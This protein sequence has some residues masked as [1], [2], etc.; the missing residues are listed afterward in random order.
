MTDEPPIYDYGPGLFSE[1][2]REYLYDSPRGVDEFSRGDVD[3][4]EGTDVSYSVSKIES[5]SSRE[6][7]VRSRIRERLVNGIHDLDLA[8]FMQERDLD[9]LANNHEI[10][11][12]SSTRPLSLFVELCIRQQRADDPVRRQSL[13]NSDIPNNKVQ[14]MIETELEQGI[15]EGFLRCRYDVDDIEVDISATPQI[16]GSEDK[17]SILSRENLAMAFKRGELSVQDFLNELDRRKK[18]ETQSDS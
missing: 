5:G 8:L 11:L 6:R 7:T 12:F 15:R 14:K 18:T 13:I 16:D 17:W 1:T 3:M 9:Q 10:T 2:Q 4:P